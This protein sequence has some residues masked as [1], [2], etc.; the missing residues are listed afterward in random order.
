MTETQTPPEVQPQATDPELDQPEPLYGAEDVQAALGESGQRALA[1]AYFTEFTE[2]SAKQ[3]LT[4]AE[5]DSMINAITHNQPWTPPEEVSITISEV[6]ATP[7]GADV[8]Q[9]TVTWTTDVVGDSQVAYGTSPSYGT[10]TALDT[11]QVTHHTV[12]LTGLTAGTTYHYSVVSN[13]INSPDATFDTG[14]AA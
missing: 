3:G 11:A 2:T 10:S 12:L 9:C 6:L 14:G 5:A 8:T 1:Q 7:D 13:T 4:K